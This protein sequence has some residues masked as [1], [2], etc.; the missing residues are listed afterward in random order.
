MLIYP[1]L[2]F[3]YRGCWNGSAVS[4]DAKELMF[5]KDEHFN[6]KCSV[7]A[8]MNFYKYFAVQENISGQV[9]FLYPTMSC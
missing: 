5:G 9:G 6:T 3:A 4:D 1:F 2:A 7:E 8:Q